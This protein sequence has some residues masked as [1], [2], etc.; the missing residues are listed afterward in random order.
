MIICLQTSM[1]DNAHLSEKL[2]MSEMNG[3]KLKTKLEELKAEAVQV[4]DKF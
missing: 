2:L 4:S 3:E 1:E